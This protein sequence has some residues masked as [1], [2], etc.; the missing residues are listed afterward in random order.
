MW[1]DYPSLL[2]FPAPHIRA[3]TRETV[4]AEK[5]HAMVLLGLRNSRMKDY[6]DVRSLLREGSID[7]TTM[8]Q[9][10]AATFKRRTTPLPERVPN[11]LSESFADDSARQA[12]WTAFPTRNRL[13]AP[14]LSVVID[15]VREKLMPVIEPGR[16]LGTALNFAAAPKA[17]LNRRRSLTARPVATRSPA[18]R[19]TS[20]SN[21]GIGLV[22]PHRQCN[23]S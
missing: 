6:F 4:L 19:T 3:Y 12:Q 21:G 22:S 17:L 5:L 7:E 15:E 14:G 10:I 20:I 13:L 9:A 1:L 2:E 16:I 11:G 8:A 23:R 18:H